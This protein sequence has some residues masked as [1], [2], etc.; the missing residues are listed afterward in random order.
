MSVSQADI[1]VAK[2]H[3][4]KKYEK[5]W[6]EETKGTRKKSWSGLS[7]SQKQE[8]IKEYEDKYYGGARQ[9]SLLYE[10]D[11]IQAYK[12]END[13]NDS[14]SIERHIT[15]QV[16]A[17]N[18]AKQQYNDKTERNKAAMDNKVKS[19]D[20]DFSEDTLSSQ[21]SRLKGEGNEIPAYDQGQ[22]TDQT[23]PQ[24]NYS[25][26]Y[27]EYGNNF[28]ELT[29]FDRY[30]NKGKG[31]Y[32]TLA[33]VLKEVPSFSMSTTW[34]KGPASTISDTVKGFMCSS[35]MEMVTTLGGHD[36]AWMNLDEGTDRTYASTNRPS[37]SLNFKLFTTDT[38]GSKKLSSWRTWLRALAL[39][40]TPSIDA[41]VNVAEMAD[42]VIDGVLGSI[43]LVVNV[44]NTAKDATAGK[45]ITETVTNLGTIV[46]NIADQVT[47]KIAERD[48]PKRVTSTAN[49]NNF[50]GAKL[51][52]LRI[53]PFIFN[54]PLIVY[55][56][57]WGVT[58]SKEI[59]VKT[60]EPIWI[61]FKITCEMDQIASAPVWK[62]YMS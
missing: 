59:N 56:S 13:T 21:I 36:R 2:D 20:S 57:N 17:V 52:K 8:Y 35:L 23:E 28:F 51:W 14:T 11:P 19:G 42:N 12:D 47:G 43:D 38:I 18:K 7:D 40:A 44:A 37:F 27:R 39:Y 26:L 25:D 62:D 55:I 10:D 61:E 5:M 22:A 45:N 4:S 16:N 34:E 32:Y 49:A 58:Y 3:V 33:G 30:L 54:K 31:G 53:L 1:K 50:Y 48:G 60:G 9:D 41:K 15:N 46:A 29:T 6:N 24:V